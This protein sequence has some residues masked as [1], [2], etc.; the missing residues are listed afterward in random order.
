MTPAPASRARFG[1]LRDAGFS[2][3]EMMMVLVI[4]G[5]TLA[6]TVPNITRYRRHDQ[7]RMSAEKFRAICNLAQR[8]AMAT[9]VDHRV[10]YE[11][12]DE[13][14]FYLERLNG[15]DWEMASGDTIRADPGISLV[16]STDGSPGN[17]VLTFEPLGTVEMAD[18]P[19]TVQF[20]N[21][22]RD[23]STVRVVRT[24]RMALRHN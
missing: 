23:T 5:I 2:M 18:V 9:R 8:K 21:T 15:T 6:A 7:V 12:G 3:V 13:P 16:G 19:A 10:V 11:P 20:Y 17:T 4:L 1:R 22:H 14:L 24:G